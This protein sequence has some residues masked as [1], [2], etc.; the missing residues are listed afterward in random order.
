MR[1]KTAA[2]KTAVKTAANALAVALLALAALLLSSCQKAEPRPAPQVLYD[3][4]EALQ[5][6]QPGLDVSA[7]MGFADAKLANFS[8]S[9][10]GSG[11]KSAVAAKASTVFAQRQ[12]ENTTATIGIRGL[13]PFAGLDHSLKNPDKTSL[14]TGMAY[15]LS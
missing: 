7:C 3:K 15:F 5:Q 8:P 11:R 1:S 9:D 12:R 14:S 6:K 13:D 2:V 4:C 10:Y